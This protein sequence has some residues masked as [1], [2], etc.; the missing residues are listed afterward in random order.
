MPPNP[1]GDAAIGAFVEVGAGRGYVRFAGT[2]SFAPGK[3]VGVE[4]QEPNGKN[5][6]SVA[7]VRYFEC[8]PSY[9]VFVRASQAKVVPRPSTVRLLRFR[10]VDLDSLISS[11]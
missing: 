3:W 5:D 4:L 10:R 11:T 2:T 7:G 1:G 9:G 8:P 6:G